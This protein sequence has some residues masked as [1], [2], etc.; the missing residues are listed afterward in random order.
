MF[1]TI[2]TNNGQKGGYLCSNSA[3]KSVT[4]VRLQLYIVLLKNSDDVLFSTSKQI[5]FLLILLFPLTIQ[6]IH[7]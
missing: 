2:K 1:F 4:E 7:F 3:Y 6:L 5:Q